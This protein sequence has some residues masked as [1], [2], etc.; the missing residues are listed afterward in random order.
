MSFK[1]KFGGWQCSLVQGLETRN[2]MW[3]FLSSYYISPPSPRLT[4]SEAI[5]GSSGILAW[6]HSK[7][8]Y[9][10]LQQKH[11]FTVYFYHIFL[12]LHKLCADNSHLIKN[13][14]F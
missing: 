9:L 2:S 1:L 4:L 6:D 8:D 11:F 13:S 12:V 14:S 3:P 10:I 7:V 5:G